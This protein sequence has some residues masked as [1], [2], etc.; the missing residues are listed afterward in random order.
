MTKSINIYF[1][2]IGEKLNQ[3]REEVQNLKNTYL[4]NLQIINN[5]T[6]LCQELIKYNLI[7]QNSL[8]DVQKMLTALTSQTC[9]D[10]LSYIYENTEGE[11]QSDEFKLNVFNRFKQDSYVI[12][13]LSDYND[14]TLFKLVEFYINLS[15]LE[16]SEI[17]N[18]VLESEQ[19]FIQQK[20]N[21]NNVIKSKLQNLNVDI[22][23]L[24]QN[25]FNEDERQYNSLLINISNFCNE[26]TN[27]L[28][29]IIQ[30][31]KNNKNIQ[32]LQFKE[33]MTEDIENVIN[34]VI[35]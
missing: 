33:K 8:I 29:D 11:V 3:Q 20:Q 22:E 35:L 31:N 32:D 12:N 26:I 6:Y 27:A 25:K 34:T 2:S 21:E 7:I 1:G 16:E 10:K 24:N 17:I 18:Q 30:K 9:L 4:I 5:R 19:N 15:S 14:Q 23:S 13:N 28:N